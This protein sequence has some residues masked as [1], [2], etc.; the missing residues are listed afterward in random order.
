M[1]T[2]DNPGG[3]D[4]EAVAWAKANPND[5]RAKRILELNGAR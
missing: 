3:G 4:A 5:P 1:A 2:T